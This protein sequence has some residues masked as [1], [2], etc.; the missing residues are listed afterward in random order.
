MKTKINFA[1]IKGETLPYDT[2]V[3]LGGTR[4]QLL[5]YCALNFDNALTPEERDQLTTIVGAVGRTRRL[6]NGAYLLWLRDY[7]VTF[8][9]FGI[10]AHE[11][12]HVADLMLRQA[13]LALSND[14]DE[15]WAYHIEWLTRRVYTAFNFTSHTTARAH[16]P[17]LA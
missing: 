9:D 5:A 15:I 7:P 10:L 14:S 6:N 17:E 4:E 3:C 11:I 8:K 12:F 16:S 2:L 13:G 1:L